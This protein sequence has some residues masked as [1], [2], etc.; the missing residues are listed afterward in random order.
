MKKI[1]TL[2][3]LTIMNFSFSQDTRLF[4]NYWYL[5]NIIENGVSNIPPTA[6]MGI[7]FDPPMFYAHACLNMSATVTFENNTTN[8]SATNFQYC[9][10]MCN[11]PSADAYETNKYFPF[12]NNSNDQTTINYFTYSISESQGVKTLSINSTLNKQAIYS[13]VMLSNA[14]FE[15]LDFNLYPNPSAEYIEIKLNNELTNNGTLE[16]YNEIGLLCKTEKLISNT[17]RMETK[18]LSSGIYFV[19]MK[20][21]NETIT[22]KLIKK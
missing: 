16:L 10:C 4:D 6:N 2:T 3:L 19:K 21:E 17:T 15:K 9:L 14:S 11:N 5:T 22:K 18:D 7:S 1:Y 12:L 13:S 20:T 8:F